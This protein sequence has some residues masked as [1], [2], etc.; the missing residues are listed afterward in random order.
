MR[1]ADTKVDIGGLM[2]CC[3]STIDEYVIEHP[4]DEATDLI[5]DCRY[6]DPGNEQIMLVAGRWKWAGMRREW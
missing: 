4:D 2:R 1:M 3:L 5:I 6:E